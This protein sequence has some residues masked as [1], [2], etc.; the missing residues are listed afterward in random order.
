MST[1]LTDVYQC[2]DLVNEIKK[3]Y[4][5][6]DEDIQQMGIF[7]YL[8]EVHANILQNSAQTAAENALEGLPTK[9]KFPRNVLNHAYSL[10][11]STEAIPANMNV[12]V[13]LPEDRI[14]ANVDNSGRFYIDH[15]TDINVEGH[16]FHFD[17]D[18]IIRR[19]VLPN[20][21]VTY[22]AQYDMREKN[23]I[24]HITNP[25]IKSIGRFTLS[26]TK[27]LAIQTSIKQIKIETETVTLYNTNPLQ[28]KTFTF[29][30]PKQLV[31][32]TIKVVE[33][34]NT[35]E[36]EPVYDGLVSQTNSKYINYSFITEDTI[37]CIF[38]KESYQPRTLSTVTITKYTCDGSA[39]NFTYTTNIQTNISSTKYNYS[40]VWA[41]LRPL[42]SSVGGE[43]FKSISELKGII[44]I[45][46]LS[47]GTITNTTDLYN[48][49]NSI[50]TE[51]RKIYF[52]KK[53]DSFERLYYAYLSL[54]D[55]YNNIIP[56]NTIDLQ[57]Q[58]Q[59]FDVIDNYH[60]Q[61]FPGNII[62]F[63]RNGVGKAISSY[64]D[65][66]ETMTKYRQSGYLYTNIFNIVLNK[67]PFYISYLLT[68]FNDTFDVKFDYINQASV[69]QYV[70]DSVNWKREWFNH[71]DQYT[72][73]VRLLQNTYTNLN[74]LFTILNVTTGTTEEERIRLV[75]V[76]R[77]KNNK[78]IRYTYGKCTLYNAQDGLTE[79]QVDFKTD[80]V[81]S[82]T[83]QVKITNM[84]D[85][86]STYIMEAY[87][88]KEVY[89]EFYVCIKLNI[90]YGGREELDR[91]V[92]NM[93]GWTCCNKYST[94]KPLP[95]YY[96]YTKELNTFVNVEQAGDNNLYFY[97]N[98]V[99]MIQYD[100]ISSEERLIEV[101]SQLQ[102][103][104]S[105]I[106]YKLE[107]I[108]DGFGFDIK[109]FNTYGPAK[110]FQVN[111]GDKLDNITMTLN[112]KTKPLLGANEDYLTD[113]T[114]YVKDYIENFATTISALHIPNL[115]ADVTKAFSDVIEYFEFTGFNNYGHSIQHIYR[116]DF[117]TKITEVPEILRID[118]DENNLPKINIEVSST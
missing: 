90:D 103:V 94:D 111:T 29:K 7:G 36:L 4:I 49:F 78:T 75:A 105:Y 93:F 53:L 70:C 117:E 8:G 55:Q 71:P 73:T 112:F 23:P 114:V 12:M 43:D 101:L 33:G 118:V 54:K 19:L 15:T 108:E 51:D 82:K 87:F 100:Y 16:T 97:I 80:N 37:R 109:L 79:F 28:L 88:D 24:S 113:L 1:D 86:K 102:L 3:K 25:Y 30:I 22:S 89:L 6:I 39:G 96:N 92:P 107:T 31:T 42:T 69:I 83:M 10:G 46:Q 106:E 32:F 58:R 34:E 99:P 72:L 67:N 18:I 84:Y 85:V 41:I 74:N 81:M 65:D 68:T 45:E 77:N 60:Y 116:E 104:R 13:F 91:I 21:E 63:T 57:I 98:K 50:N 11:I 52:L 61:L 40:G 76:L 95:L 20:K 66:E 62:H 48:F 110:F 115:Q 47:R 26:N 2:Y 17:Y 14:V 44:P 9:A 35:Y 56:S 5:D 38:K 59:Q 27:V 64:K